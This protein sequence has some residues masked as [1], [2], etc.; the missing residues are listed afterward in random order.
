MWTDVDNAQT[1][2]YRYW[3]LCASTPLHVDWLIDLH[4]PQA[5]VDVVITCRTIPST[6]TYA[7]IAIE[8]IYTYSTVQT[9]LT[10]T[11]SWLPLHQWLTT[12]QSV[13]RCLARAI[14][15][16]FIDLFF[17]ERTWP[18]VVTVTAESINA[19]H[20]SCITFAWITLLSKRK[21]DWNSPSPSSH[22]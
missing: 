11:K 19:I 5:F 14:P 16:A 1:G 7:C 9:W 15:R 3:S 21:L 4:S 12:L 6:G 22:F 20:T 2:K 10:I 13:T 8:F 17:T 18:S